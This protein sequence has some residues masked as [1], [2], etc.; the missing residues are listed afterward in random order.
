MAIR[1]YLINQLLPA[2]SNINH[3]IEGMFYLV[4]LAVFIRW[5]WPKTWNNILHHIEAEIDNNSGFKD[6]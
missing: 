6:K 3:P 1:E 4:V 5:K 2:L